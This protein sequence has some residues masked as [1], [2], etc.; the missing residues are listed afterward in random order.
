VGAVIGEI[1]C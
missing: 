1:S